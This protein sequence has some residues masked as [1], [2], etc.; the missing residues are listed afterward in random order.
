[1]IRHCVLFSFKEET[2]ENEV[3]RIEDEFHLLKFVIPEIVE[4]EWGL[5]NSPE[6]KT[7]GFTHM[8]LLSFSSL[9]DRDSYLVHPEH[10]AFSEMVGP[11]IEDVL[12][13]DY[14]I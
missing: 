1:M 3:R 8:F 2:T 13:F 4:M 14:E 5:N 6:G 7:H 12:V 10:Q 9:T 11:Y